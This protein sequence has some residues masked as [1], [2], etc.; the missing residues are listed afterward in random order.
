MSEGCGGWG[1]GCRGEKRGGW[2]R[3]GKWWV[4]GERRGRGWGVGGGT[5]REG[6]QKGR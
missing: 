5:G 2:D 1:G 6:A 4:R 3:R